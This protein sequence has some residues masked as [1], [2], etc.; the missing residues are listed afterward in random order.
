MAQSLL[1]F[2]W[3]FIGNIIWNKKNNT[4]IQFRPA[5]PRPSSGLESKRR[6][7]R[8]FADVSK[9]KYDLTTGK[10]R[11]TAQRVHSSRILIVESLF[12]G[13]WMA[14]NQSYRVVV[15]TRCAKL[16]AC[17]WDSCI[18]NLSRSIL[19]LRKLDRNNIEQQIFR[20][21]SVVFCQSLRTCE[22]QLF[23]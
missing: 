16:S 14:G 8:T 23:L 12:E 17:S 6:D 4:L 9:R 19:L 18:H 20:W 2:W 15:Q 7:T 13:K 22:K 5:E 21:G 11:H 10:T 3:A 1:R